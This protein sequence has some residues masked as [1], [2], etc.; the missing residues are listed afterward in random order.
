MGYKRRK[1]THNVASLFTVLKENLE[2]DREVL[3]AY[4]FGSY[5]R[6]KP[7]PL[8]DVDIAVYLGDDCD[9]FSKKLHLVGNVSEI[10]KTDEVDIV[11]LNELPLSLIHSVL[12]TGK[13]LF[14]KDERKRVEFEARA[15]TLYCDAEPLRK[16]VSEA[17]IKRIKEG[18]YGMAVS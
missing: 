3:F 16:K 4:I 14:C 2:R 13:L 11:I 1:I 17:L 6:G 8:S 5:G 9:F 15:N 10:L 12:K 7:S 18:R